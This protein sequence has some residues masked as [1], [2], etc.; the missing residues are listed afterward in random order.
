MHAAAVKNDDRLFGIVL[1]CTPDGEVDRP[2]PRCG[3]SAL[4]IAAEAHRP[5]NVKA[6]VERGADIHLYSTIGDTALHLVARNGDAENTVL[7][8]KKGADL[9]REN[10]LGCCA[11]QTATV[12]R[13]ARSS[14]PSQP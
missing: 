14:S 6:L 8:L 12:S 9:E 11:R 10:A 13:C 7:L 5:G 3:R 2:H 1:R 4:L